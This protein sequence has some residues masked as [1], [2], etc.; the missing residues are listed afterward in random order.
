[1]RRLT[2]ILWIICMIQVVWGQ[3]APGK[4][5]VEFTDKDNSPYSV[6]RPWEFLSTRALERRDVASI[7][8]TV[9]DLPVNPDYVQA[10]AA[11]GVEVL[12]RSKWMNGITIF[13]VDPSVIN[14]IEQ[15]P[16]VKKVVSNGPGSGS[17]IST[18]DKFSREASLGNSGQSGGTT[19]TVLSDSSA[20]GLSFTQVHMVHTD[21]MH[22]LGFRGAGKVIA[23]L[24][25]GFQNADIHPAL[26][27]LWLNNR[28]LGVKDFVTPGGN[29]FTGHPHGTEVLSVMGGYMPGQ[30]IGTAPDASFWL[31][32]SED[33]DSEYLVEEYNWISAAEFAD[34]AGADIINSSLGYTVFDDSTQNHTCADMTGSTTPVTRGANMAF[35]KGILVVNSAGNEGGNPNWPCVSAPADG[36]GVLAVAAVDSLRQRASLSSTGKVEGS[37]VKPN[38]AAMG[39][40]TVLALPDGSI[41][42]RSGTSF[43][44]PVIAGSA[45][46]L[47][48]A[49]PQYSNATLKTAIEESGSQAGSPDIF[50]GYGIPDFYTAYERLLPVSA[51]HSPVMITVSPNPFTGE[52]PLRVDLSLAAAQ[53]LLVS[54]SY[55]TGRRVSEAHTFYCTAG[56]NT[57][58]LNDLSGLRP[59]LYLLKIG[60]ISGIPVSES[61]KV[62]KI[63]E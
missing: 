20:Y 62:L 22:D 15:L 11:F 37:Y 43:S 57:F 30:L 63:G 31:L 60:S 49:F 24:D 41:S 29:V 58:W 45:A 36:T 47:W 54:F 4:Y 3:V 10:V 23:V 51:V 42:R 52:Q 5:F 46:C 26:D 12:T 39:K 8:I 17:G 56:R 21:L 16:F 50:L 13:T 44:S 32:R 40:L 61:L 27:S 38:I 2:G 6:D 7:A 1:M 34:S 35:S 59:G 33:G 28:I 55:I 9:D 53:Q 14:L 18:D 19:S 48:Q 25:A